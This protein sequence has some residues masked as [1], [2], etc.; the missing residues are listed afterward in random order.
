MRF[1]LPVLLVLSAVACSNSNSPTPTTTPPPTP[2]RVISVTGNLNFGPV[3]VGDSRTAAVT[4]A[5]SGTAPLTITG[6]SGPCGGFFTVSFS[7]GTIAA[8]G[9]QPITVRFAPTAAANCNGTL[10]VNGDQTSGTNT[11]AVTATAVAGFSRDL[12][13]TWRGTVGADAI[14]ALTQSGT[15]LSGTF[16]SISLRGNVSGSVSS[17]GQV[18]LTVA[19]SGFASFTLN[20]QADDAGNVIS[21]QVNGSGF[22]NAPFTIRR[23]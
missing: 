2:T 1:L 9:S 16:D 6:L 5:N 13:G 17:T 18:T 14:I 7:S 3:T 10:T 4:I 8:G 20:G 11:L 23:I 15:T 19:V 21:G 22:Q 12:T